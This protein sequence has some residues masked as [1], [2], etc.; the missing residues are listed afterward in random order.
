MAA[1][2]N[3]VSQ[4]QIEWQ[5]VQ[6]VKAALRLTLD[7]EV[8]EVGMPSKLSSVRFTSQSFRRHLER[9]ISLEEEGGY[10]TQ[11]REQ[12][13]HLAARIAALREEHQHFRAELARLVA[14]LERMTGESPDDF[15]RAC[16]EFG[17]LLDQVDDHDVNEADLIQGAWWEDE[18]GEGG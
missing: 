11:V 12:K 7:W 18:G 8:G 9:L 5:I 2:T 13:P 17:Q 1:T 4:C 3:H 14:E 10:L 16:F 6:H 15:Q